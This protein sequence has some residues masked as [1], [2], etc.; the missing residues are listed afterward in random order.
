M[1]V[2]STRL[3]NKQQKP[4]RY[5]RQRSR[6]EQKTT[7]IFILVY[8]HAMVERG[9][10]LP[11]LTVVLR[12]N[13]N[14]NEIGDIYDTTSN[15]CSQNEGHARHLLFTVQSPNFILQNGHRG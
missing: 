9:R 13:I 2:L 3:L 14:G 12:T 4:V 15:A 10:C 6:L 5:H 1:L 7:S 8:M 11:D